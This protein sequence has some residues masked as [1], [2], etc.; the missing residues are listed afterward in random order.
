MGG[1]W[2]FCKDRITVVILANA[3]IH[4][5]M[6]LKCLRKLDSRVRET[7]R[8]NRNAPPTKHQHPRGFPGIFAPKS[9]PVRVFAFHDEQTLTD[10]PLQRRIFLRAAARFIY[11]IFQRIGGDFFMRGGD[12][13]DAEFVADAD[14]I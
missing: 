10:V 8:V 7:D 3:G 9:P 6:Q 11:R 13:I 14:K 1:R 4:F 12:R 2:K 5:S